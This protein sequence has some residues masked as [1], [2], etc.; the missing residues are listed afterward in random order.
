MSPIPVCIGDDFVAL[1]CPDGAQFSARVD[2]LPDEHPTVR[3]VALLAHYAGDVLTGQRP[4][5]YSDAAAAA[6]A[7][8]EAL[9][10]DIY[11]E[12]IAAG[13][14]VETIAEHVCLPVEQVRARAGDRDVVRRARPWRYTRHDGAT[15]RRVSVCG[16]RVRI[17]QLPQ[18]W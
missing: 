11:R 13:A 14:S 10:L 17:T 9:P 4:G 15:E 18:P 3:F 1:V 7:R 6:W 12:A 2:A 8:Q 16:G 5:P